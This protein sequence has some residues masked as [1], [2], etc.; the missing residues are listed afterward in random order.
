MPDWVYPV[1]ITSSIVIV[2]VILF[3]FLVPY[4]CY[5]MAFYISDAEKLKNYNFVYPLDKLYT[6]YMD[7]MIAYI[8]NSK[9]LPHQECSITSF[10][11]LKLYAKFYEYKKGATIEIMMPGYKG[12]AER[13]LS[14]GIE[15][16][17]AVGHSVL[18]VDQRASG[19]SEGNVISFGINERKDCLKWIDFV[20][21]NIDPDAK[22][23]LTGVSMGA[24]TVLMTSGEKLPKNVIGVLADCGYS[25]PKEIIM[26]Y[27]KNMKLPPKLCYPFIKLGARLY[28]KFNL[29][30]CSPIEAIKNA[31]V[32]II[33][34]HGDED[35]FVPHYMSV[36]MY[37]AYQNKKRLVSVKGA[38]HGASYVV[39]SKLYI[40]ELK[41]FFK[42]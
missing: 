36:N 17:F 15:R 28:A 10:D 34:Y 3:I 11:E 4:I 13:D 5:K 22:I 9:K 39:D 33:F 35:T 20:I 26:L 24:A 42:D 6:Q 14:G 7:K 25:T 30:E 8:E 27:T 21:E 18:L 37:K 2:I 40:D 12:N 31:N 29:S 41:E 32:P 1:I 38:G 23:I 16:A 19:K